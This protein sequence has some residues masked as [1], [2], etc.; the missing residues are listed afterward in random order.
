MNLSLP[1]PRSLFIFQG[2]GEADFNLYSIE[3]HSTLCLD[4]DQ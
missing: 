3:L 1:T 2:G 4:V